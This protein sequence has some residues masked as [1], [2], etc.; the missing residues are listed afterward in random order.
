VFFFLSWAR[1]AKTPEL[2]MSENFFF[3]RKKVRASRRGIT[4]TATAMVAAIPE[5]RESACARMYV[6]TF[7]DFTNALGKPQSGIRPLRLNFGGFVYRVITTRR[8]CLMAI[9][10]W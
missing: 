4:A 6:H 10:Y 9:A 2:R 8:R 3:K 7:V 1:R 5:A